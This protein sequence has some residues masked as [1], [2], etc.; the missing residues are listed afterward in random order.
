MRAARRVA[1]ASSTGTTMRAAARASM[2]A[3][4]AR[5]SE[6]ADG[7]GAGKHLQSAQE[8]RRGGG[9]RLERPVLPQPSSSS[10]RNNTHR[11]EADGDAI[12]APRP[13]KVTRKVVFAPMGVRAG[14]LRLQAP[15]YKH[16]QG[17]TAAPLRSASRDLSRLV[18]I[19]YIYLKY[20]NNTFC[21]RRRPRSRKRPRAARSSSRDYR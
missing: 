18:I 10:G 5:R 14:V 13:P 15:R 11:C 17:R 19:E 2:H 3:A 8:L 12:G 20:Q 6:R 7:R 16:R 9:W 21:A 1:C 4:P